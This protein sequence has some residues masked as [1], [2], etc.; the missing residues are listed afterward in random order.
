M[1]DAAFKVHMLPAQ[2][3]ELPPSHASLD[4]KDN[5]RL[6]QRSAS[7]IAG[8]QERI[9]FALFETT[10]APPRDWRTSHKLHRVAWDPKT[11]FLSRNLDRVGNGIHFSDDSCRSNRFKA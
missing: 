8:R 6:K 7:A 5:K 10:C 3:K 11:P 2:F 4:G 9:F 1:C